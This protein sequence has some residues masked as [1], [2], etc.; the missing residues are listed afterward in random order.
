MSIVLAAALLVSFCGYFLAYRVFIR[1]AAA[2]FPLI[3]IAFT[4]ISIYLSGLAGSLK[5]GLFAVLIAGIALIPVSA[6]KGRDRLKDI[7]KETLSDPSW[8]FMAAGAVWLYIITRGTGI[9]HPD[10]FSHWYK[11]CKI[12]HY[13]S[14]YPTTPDLTYTTYPPGTATWIWFVTFFTGFGPD[15]CFFAHSLINLASLNAFFVLLKNRSGVLYRAGIFFFTVLMS[16]VLCSM[17]VNTYCLLTDTTLAL[18]PLAAVFWILDQGESRSLRE[19]AVLVLMMAFEAMV[20][21]PGLVFVVFIFFL[22]IAERR[23]TVRSTAGLKKTVYILPLIIPI[24]VFY[25][26]VIRA[27]HVFGDLELS[28]QGFSLTRFLA[29]YMNKTGEQVNAIV[30]RYFYEVFAFFGNMTRQM[31]TIWIAMVLSG[32][33]LVIMWTKKDTRFKE[34]RKMVIR[35]GVFALL[36][37]VFLLLAYIFSMNEKEANATRLTCFFRYIGSAAIFVWG[38]LSFVFFD[39]LSRRE[40][41]KVLIAVSVIPVS[42]LLTGLLMYNIGYIAG[43]DH[44]V[45]DEDYTTAG[46]DLCCEY[47]EERTEY[48]EY[49]YFMIY[50]ENDIIDH[51]P[52]KVRLIGNVY[53]RSVHVYTYTLQELEEG[54]VDPQYLEPIRS[55]DYLVTMGDFSDRLDIIRE[56]VDVTDYRPGMTELKGE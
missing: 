49:T 47:G 13:E 12:I 2:F 3:F 28:G 11:I 26:Y 23:K 29:M 53:F 38:M 51:H 37:S 18:I 15:K 19:D 45:R 35:A 32:T 34:A 5:A 56:Y 14:A 4:V 17:N 1:R 48:N 41:R 24:A 30:G 21:F 16:V 46:W 22:W 42:T 10:D 40:G 52:P 31:R 27:D 54:T 6:I 33:G 25:L 8:I 55:S 44:Y 9:S 39:I 43:F 7:V 50:D 20:K 36:Y